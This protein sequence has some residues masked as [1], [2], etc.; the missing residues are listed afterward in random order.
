MPGTPRVEHQELS[1]EYPTGGYPIIRLDD[2]FEQHGPVHGWTELQR[3]SI[4]P[5]TPTA[6]AEIGIGIM[7]KLGQVMSTE[8][9]DTNSP[10]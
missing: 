8:P 5:P 6:E 1:G 2:V 3:R 4:C 7:K 10:K 9:S